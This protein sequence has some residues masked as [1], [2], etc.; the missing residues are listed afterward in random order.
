M[1]TLRWYGHGGSIRCRTYCSEIPRSLKNY[2]V[3]LLCIFSVGLTAKKLIVARKTLTNPHS[4]N[5]AV[6]YFFI[7]LDNP[8]NN[9]NV[10]QID[11]LKTEWE[12]VILRPTV[13]RPVCLG[14]KNP[15]GAYDQRFI[16]VRQ[17]RFCW[18]GAPSLK[19]GRVC[20]WLC[21][22][23]N[24]LTFYMLSCVIHTHTHTH[25]FSPF[26]IHSHTQSH[27]HI[28]TPQFDSL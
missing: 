24:I 26:L 19:R 8:I 4:C 5:A 25:S 20:P 18:C 27:T 7:V 10:I 6:L 15:S 13:S 17:L 14:V 1:L 23:Y 9:V 12:W 22:M 16:T 28:H 21:T 3:F 2:L 11:P